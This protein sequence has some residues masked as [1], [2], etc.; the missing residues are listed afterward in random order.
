[1]NRQ[2]CEYCGDLLI[3][4]WGPPNSTILLVGEFPG[5][6]DIMEGIAPVGVVGQI[7]AN[8]L[9][10]VGLNLYSCRFVNLWQHAK[11]DECNLDWHIQQMVKEFEN[12]KYI[13]L[14]GSEVTQTLIV[15]SAMELSGLRIK[16]NLAPKAIVYASPNP[17]IL[18]HTPVGE[19]RDA[20]V[21]FR[22]EIK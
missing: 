3:Q 2:K 8:E 13:L 20:L 9:A 15:K 14:M 16:L 12:R 22:K 19:F 6:D 4:P 1:M 5:K 10:K 18:L 11:N 7:L 17:A 21:K